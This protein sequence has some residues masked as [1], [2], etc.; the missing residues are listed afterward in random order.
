MAARD[1]KTP[2]HFD[3]PDGDQVDLIPWA[4]V[5]DKSNTILSG[6]ISNLASINDD[7]TRIDNKIQTWIDE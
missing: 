7:L 1:E 4:Y 3:L 2:V 5:V 6:I